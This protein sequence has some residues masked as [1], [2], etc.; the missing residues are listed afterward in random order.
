MYVNH[1]QLDTPLPAKIITAVFKNSMFIMI[2]KWQLTMA[3]VYMDSYHFI[4]YL[5]TPCLPFI[6]S[7]YHIFIRSKVVYIDRC[8][9]GCGMLYILEVAWQ[10]VL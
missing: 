9:N 4:A 8:V 5:I 2:G 10:L 3:V 6:S 1:S 7:F